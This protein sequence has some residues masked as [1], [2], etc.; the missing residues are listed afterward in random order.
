M[1]ND[2][3]A[4]PLTVRRES[5]TRQL[6]DDAPVAGFGVLIVDD[7]QLFADGLARLLADEDGISVLGVATSGA[8]ALVR[9]AALRP[10]VVLVDYAMPDQDGVAITAQIK[11]QDPAVMVVM[12]TGSADDRVLLAAIEAGCSGAS[13]C[14]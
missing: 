14:I 3:I 9:V 8:Q 6:M 4:R 11:A 5:P 2:Q 1:V 10:R 12:V 13:I 7:H